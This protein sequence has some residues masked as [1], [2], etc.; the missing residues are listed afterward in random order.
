MAMEQK[1]LF[2]TGTG[3]VRGPAEGGWYLI[4]LGDRVYEYQS[5]GSVELKPGDKV[6]VIIIAEGVVEVIG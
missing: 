6:E 2:N 4:E 5:C 1:Y 3:T